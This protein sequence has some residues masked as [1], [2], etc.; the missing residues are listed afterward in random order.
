MRTQLHTTAAAVGALAALP[1]PAPPAVTTRTAADPAQP[2]NWW[3]CALAL[4][5][6]GGLM[7]PATPR[8]RGGIRRRDRRHAA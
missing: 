1:A 6:L 5:L 8:T 2:F 3:P 4:G 7:V